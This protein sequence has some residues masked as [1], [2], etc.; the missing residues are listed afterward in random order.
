MYSGSGRFWDLHKNGTHLPLPVKTA[1]PLIVHQVLFR[2]MLTFRNYLSILSVY[3]NL[4]PYRIIIYVN[5]N[6]KLQKYDYNTWYQKAA[7]EIPCLEM[8]HLDEL[9]KGVRENN[10][11]DEMEL[12][13]TVLRKYGG[14]YVNINTIMTGDIKE[15]L[16]HNFVA[17]LTNTYLAGFLMT[18]YTANLT[19]YLQHMRIANPTYVAKHSYGARCSFQETFTGTEHCCII[20]KDIFPVDIMYDKSIFGS[21]VRNLF[22]GSPNIREPE[23]IFPPI[24]KIVHYAWFGQKNITYSMFLSFKSTIRFVKPLKIIIYVDTANLGQYFDEI[25]LFKCVQIVYYGTIQSI[26]QRRMQ[27]PMHAS[28]IMRADILLRYGGIYMDWDVFWLKPVDDL[29]SLGYE[30]IATLDHYK[31]MPPRRLFPDTINMGIVLARPGSRFI[32]LWQDTFKHYV[33]NHP[34]F[35]SVETVYKVYE[36]HPDLLYIEKRLQ[37]MCYKLNCHPLWLSNYKDAYVHNTF[38]F[39]KD[40]YSV[41]FTHPLPKAF[42]SEKEVK[43]S[44]GFFG[45]MARYV[46]G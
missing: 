31:D 9:D 40:A 44:E 8:T 32:A 3:K 15:L 27:N 12:V 17:G 22:Y 25:R 36:A 20:Q 29:L 45:D 13:L 39:T 4:R 21:A 10:I 43:T 19:L 33:G 7:F 41:H 1:I 18:A 14:I 16:K 2:N 35:H 6:F 11:R 38:D 42:T 46:H 23:R 26:F 28:D 34:T 30:T 24:P 5:E 37:V